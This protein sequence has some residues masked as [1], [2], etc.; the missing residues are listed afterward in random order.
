MQVSVEYTDQFFH[1]F[2]LSEFELEEH[3]KQEKPIQRFF[4]NVNTW[5]LKERLSS[6]SESL[7]GGF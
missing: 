3:R 1:K 7:Y 5:R 2:Q 4:K 6:L